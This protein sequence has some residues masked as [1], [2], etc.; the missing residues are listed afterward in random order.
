MDDIDIFDDPNRDPVYEDMGFSFDNERGQYFEVVSHP[1][2]GVMRRYISPRDQSP[3]PELSDA[4]TQA[5]LLSKFSKNNVRGLSDATMKLALNTAAKEIDLFDEVGAQTFGDL[6]KRA[7]NLVDKL[8][9][10]RVTITPTELEE[11]YSRLR[12]KIRDEKG[13]KGLTKGRGYKEG[14]GVGAPN[15]RKV[16]KSMFRS[17]G[18]KKSAT[19]FLGPIKN[20]VTGGTMTE[21]TTNWE[22]AGIEIPTMVP[23]LSAEEVEYMRRMKPGQGWD[24]SNPIDASILRKAKDHARMRIKQGNSPYYQDGEDQAK[25]MRAGGI[26]DN[27]DIFGYNLGGSVSEMMNPVERELPSLSPAQIAN[28]GAAFADP[29]GM[30]D[31]TG[32]YPEFPA[33]GVSVS[34]MVME[35]PRSPSLIENLSEGSYG[36]AALQ[37]IGVIPVVGGA[38]RAARNLIKGADRLEKAKK[39]GFDTETVYYHAT[40][41]FEGDTPDQEF[42]KILPSERGKLGPGIYLSPNPRY[43]ETYINEKSFQDPKFGRGGR[44]LPVFVRGKVGTSEDFGD[45]IEESQKIARKEH[46]FPSDQTQSSRKNGRRWLCWI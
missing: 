19:G 1:E 12:S 38:A 27:V 34:E 21:F 9:S 4:R 39:A 31:I 35:G 3:V 45:A 25:Q 22:D 13:S 29:L 8:R 44:V 23:T 26:V 42:T 43:S 6:E 10:G 7:L 2:Y 18:S 46:R 15:D 33:A 11:D 14:G 17:D 5:D 24:R 30:V 16:D 32:E 28:M 40:D 36:A 20:L 41:K 37:G